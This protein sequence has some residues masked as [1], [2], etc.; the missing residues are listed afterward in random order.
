MLIENLIAHE[1]LGTGSWVGV[2]H[3]NHSI[4]HRYVVE[5]V[6]PR[7]TLVVFEAEH[8]RTL[9]IAFD[10][11]REIDG[12]SL[13]RFTAQADLNA[14]GEKIQGMT[15]RGRKPKSRV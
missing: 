15:R 6:S 14:Q 2:S 5:K 3:N 7:K 8:N 4:T 9:E 12:M 10:L 13:Q 1:L 11:V